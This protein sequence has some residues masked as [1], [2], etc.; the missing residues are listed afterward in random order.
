M[1]I[2]IKNLLSC[3]NSQQEASDKNQNEETER[4]DTFNRSVFDD[5]SPRVAH[6]ISFIPTKEYNL[7]S[8]FAPVHQSDNSFE[9]KEL[10][11]S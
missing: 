10:K 6:F 7:E 8:S 4:Q 3:A 9:I 2:I 5:H 11:N 1:R